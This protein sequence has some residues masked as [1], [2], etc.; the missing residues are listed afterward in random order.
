MRN[1]TAL[2]LIA[3]TACPVAAPG[4]ATLSVLVNGQSDILYD[5]ST[6]A[7]LDVSIVLDRNGSTDGFLSNFAGWSQFSGSLVHGGIG[8]NWIAPVETSIQTTTINDW[9]GRRPPSTPGFPGGTGGGFRFTPQQAETSAQRIDSIQGIA[10]STAIGGFL[11]DSAERLEVFRARL[12]LSGVFCNAFT[13][14]FEADLVQAFVDGF[15][16]ER[17]V[18]HEIQFEHAD[19]V[20]CPA[21]GACGLLGAGAVF[22]SRRCRARS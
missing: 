1:S 16:V 2:A 18:L 6:S 22:R 15:S 9:E 5:A 8:A 7:I 19:I 11:H 12:D 21:P 20:L 17:A 14:D 4:S 13:I 10:A 3:L